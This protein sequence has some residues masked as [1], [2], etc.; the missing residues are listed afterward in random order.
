[1]TKETRKAALKV[2]GER[3]QNGV[4][5]IPKRNDLEHE[6]GE[7]LLVAWLAATPDGKA[8]GNSIL[9]TSPLEL[10]EAVYQLERDKARVA[11]N[12]PA[13][14]SGSPDMFLIERF[15]MSELESLR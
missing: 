8:W 12:A 1:M 11:K 2:I 14:F 3:I 7:V 5:A 13:D 6:H 15:K 4:I 10:E 9:C